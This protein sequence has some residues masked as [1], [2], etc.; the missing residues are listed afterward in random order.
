MY[1]V[2]CTPVRPKPCTP[3]SQNQ[4]PCTLEAMYY[5]TLA[6]NCVPS[7]LDVAYFHHK[8]DKKAE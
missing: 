2:P 1:P 6:R 7:T 3:Y 5:V 4:V 8:F